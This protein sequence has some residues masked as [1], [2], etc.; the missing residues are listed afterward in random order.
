MKTYAIRSS[1]LRNLVECVQAAR[2]GVPD[3]SL[4]ARQCDLVLARAVQELPGVILVREYC[5]SPQARHCQA[6]RQSKQYR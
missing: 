1:T 5:A 3:D 6:F 4:F 2:D